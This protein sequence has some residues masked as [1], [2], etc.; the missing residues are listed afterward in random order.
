VETTGRP[1]SRYGSP[2]F[3]VLVYRVHYV[4]KVT[5][6]QCTRNVKYGEVYSPTRVPERWPDTPECPEEL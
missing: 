4:Q 2:A 1:L 3:N 6:C 5:V